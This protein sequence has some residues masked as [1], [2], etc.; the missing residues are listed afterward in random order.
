MNLKEILIVLLALAAGGF[1][2]ALRFNH[3]FTWP[4]R[5]SHRGQSN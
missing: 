3:R 5:R 4:R 2:T 1:I